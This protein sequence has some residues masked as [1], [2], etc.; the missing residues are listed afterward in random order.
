[1]TGYRVIMALRWGG[2]IKVARIPIPA[3]PEWPRAAI[4]RLAAGRGL[5]TFRTLCL[6]DYALSVALEAPGGEVLMEWQRKG[7][8]S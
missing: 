7:A 6:K 2:D 8:A 1:M 4:D 3:D 5:M